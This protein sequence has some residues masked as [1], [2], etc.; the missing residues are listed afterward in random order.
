MMRADYADDSQSPQIE[1]DKDKILLGS[2]AVAPVQYNRISVDAD[3][4]ILM[5]AGALQGVTKG[6]VFALYPPGT[7]SFDASQRIADACIQSVTATES[8]LSVTNKTSSDFKLYS[9]SAARAIETDHAYG[10]NRIRIDPHDFDGLP[11]APAILNLL[12]T[13]SAVTTQLTPDEKPDIRFIHTQQMSL[14]RAEGGSEI[15][16]LSPG[17]D[18]PHEIEQAIKRE[19]T[20]EFAKSLNNQGTN[21]PVQ[22]E[23]RM[24]PAIVMGDDISGIQFARD[25]PLERGPLTFADGDYATLE[26]RNVGKVDVYIA[27]LDLSSDGGVVQIWPTPNRDISDNIIKHGAPQQW[28]KL[29]DPEDLTQPAVIAL[30]KPFGTEIFKAIA[31]EDKVDF[32]RLSMPNRAAEKDALGSIAAYRV[33]WVSA[34]P[35]PSRLPSGPLRQ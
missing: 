3:G 34:P 14:V 21:S 33:N 13:L 16:T 31:T 7:K 20:W 30:G 22:I 6:S 5:D 10:D 23:V 24:V 19:I 9:L 1:G 26:V 32:S 35:L 11:E 2:L 15:A 12:G 4:N 17:A 29:W 27:I 28:Q 8:Y 18:L 25:K